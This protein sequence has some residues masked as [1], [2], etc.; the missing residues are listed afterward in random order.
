[1]I[2]CKVLRKGLGQTVRRGLQQTAG[3][4][5]RCAA[6]NGHLVVFDRREGRS[7]DEKIFR[8]D[9]S[10]GGRAITVWGM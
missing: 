1:M 3:Y 8:R 4:M 5:E 9:E 6:R 7:W 2:E 10:A